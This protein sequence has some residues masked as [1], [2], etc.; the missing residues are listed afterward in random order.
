MALEC[1]AATKPSAE[2]LHANWLRSN[3]LPKVDFPASHTKG[4]EPAHEPRSLVMCQARLGKL[5]FPCINSNV[6]NRRQ[7]A[8]CSWQIGISEVV[9]PELTWAKAFVK[10]QSTSFHNSSTRY[11]I[12]FMSA[13]EAYMCGALVRDRQPRANTSVHGVYF[14]Y[15][16]PRAVQLVHAF[17]RMHRHL[18]IKWRSISH[19]DA[20]NRSPALPTQLQ[21]LSLSYLPEV[22]QHLDS[23]ASG[24]PWK[25]HPGLSQNH[26]RNPHLLPAELS[27]EVSWWLDWLTEHHPPGSLILFFLLRTLNELQFEDHDNGMQYHKPN[28]FAT[29]SWPAEDHGQL[30][31]IF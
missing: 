30:R 21:A 14:S 8:A 22:A 9:V 5:P 4:P 23:M 24:I 7:R 13:A 3:Q 26:T 17:R 6:S 2:L 27:R 31:V 28:T 15:A 12:A 10:G 20:D 1:R 25:L 11:S 29:I 19:I 16:I 18:C